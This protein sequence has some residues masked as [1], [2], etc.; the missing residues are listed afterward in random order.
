[1]AKY[2]A[3]FDSATGM[4][5][6]LSRYLRGMDVPMLGQLPGPVEPLASGLLGA[7]NRLPRRMAERAYA[8]AGWTEAS[9]PERLAKLRAGDLAEWV[10]RHYPPRRYPVIFV[11]SASGALVHLAAALGA[12]W[13]P[14]TLLLPVRQRGVHPDAPA[15]GL[16]HCRAAGE[17]MLDANPDL[18]LHHMHDAAQDRLMIAGM[19]YFRVKWRRLPAAYRKFIRERLAPGGTLVVSDCGLRW[20]TT[21]ITDRYVFQHGA[22]G[23]L[24]PGEYR[25]GGQKVADYL[26]EHG[27]PYRR[28]D[29][30]EPDG[31]SPEAEWGFAPELLGDLRTAAPRV[32]RLGF[33][34]PEALSPAVADLYRAWYERRGIP[35]ARL[36]AESF[37]LVEPWWTLRTGS[38]PFWMTFNTETSRRA[39]AAYLDGGEPYDEIRLTLFSHGVRS[40]GVAPIAA[41]REVL[42]RA[43]KIGV[44]AGVDPRAFPR[45]FAVLAR[46]HRDLSRV[47]TT[48]PMPLPMALGEAETWLTGRPDLQWV[49][50]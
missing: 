28:W 18:L 38:V 42:E 4:L 5:R 2:V 41:W 17:A 10:V 24:S 21:R 3:S 29:A 7:A 35:A 43:R 26:A 23:G 15:D 37:V 31:E 46:T 50:L 22:L 1:M 8:T 49:T 6:A 39:L 33:T 47:R 13:L 45:D 20:P 16:R 25:E 14:Q 9:S 48:Y 34:D 27:S 44:F 12:A 30:P 40:P 11:G 32:A 19:A 36:L